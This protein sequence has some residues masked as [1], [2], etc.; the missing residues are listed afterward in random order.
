MKK[1]WIISIVLATLIYAN[2]HIEESHE[3][4]EIEKHSEENEGFNP[5]ISLIVDMGYS[6][7]SFDNPNTTE[8]L[9]IPSFVHGGSNE[10]E[11]HTHNSMSGNDGFSLNYAELI[12]G[13][14]VD[15]YFEL[16]SIFHITQDN[17]E[18]EEAYATTTSL[19]W[20]VNAKIGKF[21]SSFGYLNEKHHHNYNFN[22]APLIYNAL[23]GQHGLNDI[24]LQL[25][26]SLPFSTNTIVGV[27]ALQGT[28]EQSFGRDGFKPSD[29]TETFVGVDS[30]DNPL[31]IGYIKTAFEIGE[32][33][34]SLGVSL[35]NGKSHIAHLDDGA[36]SHAF[37][38]DTQLYGA[39]ISYTHHLF[40]ESFI[41]LSG[42]Y[43]Y[44]E[45]DGKQYIPNSTNDAWKSVSAINKKQAGFYTELIYKHSDTIS[46]GFR[47]S[48]ITQNDILIDNINKNINDD[49]SIISAMVEYNFSHKS[50][51]RVQYN[52]DSSLFDESGVKNNKDEFILQLSYT[53]GK[54]THNN[55]EHNDKKDSN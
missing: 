51:I 28:N 19:P 25:Q 17:F 36:E 23:L 32:N 20:G 15:D 13:A 38:G 2:E 30:T 48:A 18:I 6:K 24:G 4:H 45:L 41:S 29:A 31:I 22:E 1:I 52:H 39:D 16:K 40:D 42:E 9:E 46:T 11:G 55:I 10:H 12:L 26:Y 49:I 5:S 47:Y 33:R 54:H 3:E 44:R 21:N 53:I 27:E 14:R 37:S 35:A 8:H 43:L 50:R 7:E 34:L